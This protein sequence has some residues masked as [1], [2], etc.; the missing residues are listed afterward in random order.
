MIEQVRWFDHDDNSCKYEAAGYEISFHEGWWT[1]IRYHDNTARVLGSCDSLM[2]AK[3]VVER[4]IA[5]RRA[6]AAR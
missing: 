4:D 3:A 1:A 2:K 6:G 5:A